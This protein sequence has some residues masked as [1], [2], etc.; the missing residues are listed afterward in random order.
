MREF[1]ATGRISLITFYIRRFRR[2]LPAVVV[3]VIAVAIVSRRY[4]PIAQL[5]WREDAVA[6][7]MYIA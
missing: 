7:L 5:S 1:D 6:T 2:L 4:D 3:V